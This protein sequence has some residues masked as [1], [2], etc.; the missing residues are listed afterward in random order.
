LLRW[1]LVDRGGQESAKVSNYVFGYRR[2]SK[3]LLWIAE[4]KYKCDK[5]DYGVE[6][7]TV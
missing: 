2:S 1:N 4:E 6:R 3:T 7:R 5:L